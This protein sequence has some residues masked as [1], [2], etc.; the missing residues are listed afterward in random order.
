[1]TR[2]LSAGFAT[3][4]GF[5]HPEE[6]GLGS[7]TLDHA[8]K[9]GFYA[10]KLGILRAKT[11]DFTHQNLE[12]Y[13]PK[14][15][16]LRTKTWNFTRQNLGFYAPKLGILRAKTWDFTHQ[17]LEFYAPKLGIL[18]TKTWNFTRQ[19]LGFYAPKLG[20]LRAKTWDFT[21][22]NLEFYAPKLGI[23]GTKPWDF[24]RQNLG[25]YAK[26]LDF[27]TKTWDFTR[28]NLG[29]Y[30]PKLGILRSSLIWP[31][32]YAPAALAACFSTLRS[33]KSSEKHS[34]SRLS[35][36]FAHLDLLSPE[37]FSFVIFFLLLFSSLLRLFPSLLFICPYCRKFD[38]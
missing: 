5:H 1:M 12:F 32:G 35:Y 18:R 3:G 36:L 23:L 2:A 19:N 10:P 15:G 37:T 38:F 21:H 7:G 29:F 20:I 9:V 16:I 34:V 13:A 8:P 25:F 31:A 17:N 26:S 22:Q 33:H 14:L 11:W 30:A 28:Q 6:V 27:T 4:G 24:T